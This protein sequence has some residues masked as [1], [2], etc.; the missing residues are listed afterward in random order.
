MKDKFRSKNPDDLRN[1]I[2]NLVSFEEGKGPARPSRKPSKY[3]S[4]LTCSFARGAE[5]PT[6]RQR[7]EP[8]T[9]Y[10]PELTTKKKHRLSRGN[11]RTT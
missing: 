2:K 1:E 10:L 4:V 3:A 8:K 6:D 5:D 11:F 9:D 7:R